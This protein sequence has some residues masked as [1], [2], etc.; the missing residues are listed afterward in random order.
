MKFR[1]YLYTLVRILF[2]VFLVL[3]AAYN[4]IF[5]SEFLNKIDAHF[6]KTT[7]FNFSFIETLAPLVPFE[8]F[9]IGSFLALGFFTRNVL[10]GAIFLFSF[11]A[12]FLIDANSPELSLLHAGCFLV[13]LVLLKKENYNLKSADYT[14]DSFLMI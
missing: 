5:Y 7:I 14:R 11:L 2:G 8:E 12:F 1:V 10:I 6:T 13:T 4:V 9:V 3:H